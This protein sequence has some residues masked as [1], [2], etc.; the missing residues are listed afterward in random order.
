MVKVVKILLWVSMCTSIEDVLFSDDLIPDSFRC[1]IINSIPGA[2]IFYG[3]EFFLQFV[4]PFPHFPI[5]D[6]PLAATENYFQTPQ[7]ANS[8]VAE[9]SCLR[10]EEKLILN[11][12]DLEG[13]N[14]TQTKKLWT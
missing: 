8:Q 11:Q 4:H 13:L 9:K 10:F 12:Q 7:T 1:I 3:P 5:M 6:Y 14:Y 2:M